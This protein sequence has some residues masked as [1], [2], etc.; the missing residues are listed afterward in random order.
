M[1]T[2]RMFLVALCGVAMLTGTSSCKKENV[3]NVAPGEEMHIRASVGGTGGNAKTHLDG[4]NVAWDSWDAFALY[5]EDFTQGSRF[6]IDKLVGDGTTADFVGYCPGEG[7][8][9]AGYPYDIVSCSTFGTIEFA[10]PARQSGNP[11][12][13]SESVNA[14]PMVGYLAS[15]TSGMTFKLSLIHI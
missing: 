4:L 9:Y 13:Q 10:I 5:A 14:G 15:Q 8:Y 3:G 12:E 6:R 2:L 7:P 1:R 11:A